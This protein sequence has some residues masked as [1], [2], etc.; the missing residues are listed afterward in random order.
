M[1]QFL[2][3]HGKTGRT[4]RTLR[5]IKSNYANLGERG[6]LEPRLPPSFWR[7][8]GV[9]RKKKMKSSLESIYENT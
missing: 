7:N 6:T 3:L 8:Y 9:T 1:G 4:W 2:R 5:R